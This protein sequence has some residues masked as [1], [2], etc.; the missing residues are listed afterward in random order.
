MEHRKWKGC[1]VLGLLAFLM[2]TPQ[3]S[4]DLLWHSEIVSKGV[5]GEP[6]GTQIGKNYCTEEACRIESGDMVT[7]MDFQ[8]GNMYILDPEEKTYTEMIP[9]DMGKD[10]DK[11]EQERMKQMTEGMMQGAEI[12]PTNEKKRISGYTCRKYIMRMMGVNNEY[13]LSKDVEGYKEFKKINENMAKGFEKNPMLK[14]MNVMGMMKALD[15]FPV[16]TVNRMPFGGSITTTLTR[17]ERTPLNKNLFE[18]PKGYTLKKQEEV[19]A[20]AGPQQMPADMPE[21]L[22]KMMEQMMKKSGK[23]SQ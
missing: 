10:M 11:E 9:Q 2:M 20:P 6:D 19:S 23:P 21:E 16:K 3:V 22:K 17:I 8:K 4:A 18:I 15:G 14:G 7:I 1:F 5:P 13:W 12:T